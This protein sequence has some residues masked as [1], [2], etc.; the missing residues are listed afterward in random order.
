VAVLL[1]L[2][3]SFLGGA[4][5]QLAAGAARGRGRGELKLPLALLLELS[6]LQLL[7]MPHSG[8]LLVLDHDHVLLGGHHCHGLLVLVEL[9]LLRH[10]EGVKW[11]GRRRHRHWVHCVLMHRVLQGTGNGRKRSV[12]DLLGSHR[13]GGRRREPKGTIV[14]WR[15]H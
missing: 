14:C 6:L 8:Q 13:R 3:F 4:F 15:C 9:V 2:H 12:V 5:A 1:L 11:G 10:Q 7:M